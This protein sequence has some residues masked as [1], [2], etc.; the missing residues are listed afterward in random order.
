MT[1]TRQFG[2]VGPKHQG[3]T[4]HIVCAG[5]PITHPEQPYTMQMPIYLGAHYLGSFGVR[6]RY[7]AKC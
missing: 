7:R 4:K 1:P 5:L 2:T 3:Y 6:T